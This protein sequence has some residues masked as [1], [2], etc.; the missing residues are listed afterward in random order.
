MRTLVL[1]LALAVAAQAQSNLEEKYKQK[2]SKSFVKNAAWVL[3]FDAAK[4]QAA[5]RKKFI[6]AYFTRSFSP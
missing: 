5:E 1:T 2:V 4:K 6:F 3:E